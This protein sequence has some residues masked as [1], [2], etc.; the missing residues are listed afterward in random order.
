MKRLLVVVVLLGA[1][2]AARE[3]TIVFN[4]LGP[5]H[6]YFPRGGW[7]IFSQ[8][9]LIELA[10][11]FVARTSG[12][13][14]TVDLALTYSAVEGPACPV[15]VYLYSDATGAP[16]NA[17]QAF[18]GSGTPTRQLG[19]TNNTLVSFDVTSNIPITVGATYWLALKPGT[20]N[21]FDV[22]ND[23]RPVIEGSVAASVNHSAWFVYT[24]A[25]LPAFRLTATGTAQV[26]EFGN[27]LLL[28][29]WVV[30]GTLLAAA[31]YHRA[32]F[33]HASVWRGAATASA[34]IIPIMRQI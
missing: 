21:V 6:T 7:A 30:P 12:N 23:A 27:T 32:Q 4:M 24:P 14:A 29:L 31:R 28:S 18:L 34:P 5:G 25:V 2:F 15:D 8:P 26:P 3:N 13:L 33:K 19:S 22:W 17:S 11:P 10:V 1:T 16:Y 20:S 9:K